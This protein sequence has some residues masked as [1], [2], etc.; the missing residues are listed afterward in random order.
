MAATRD[1]LIQR[2]KKFAGYPE[3]QVTAMIACAEAFLASSQWST[4][5]R[6]DRAVEAL[7]SHML[8]MDRLAQDGASGAV[9]SR[10]KTVSPINGESESQTVSFAVP[11]S[12]RT[13]FERTLSQS[14]YGR[15]FLMMQDFEVEQIGALVT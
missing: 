2:W 9:I 3:E 14:V 13:A 12:G 5:E 15:T 1:T 10:S 11:A 8:H 6:Y 4:T 7:A